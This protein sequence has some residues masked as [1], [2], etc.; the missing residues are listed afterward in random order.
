MEVVKD[1]REKLVARRKA[2]GLTQSDIAIRMGTAQ[3]T[4]SEFE[5]GTKDP[6]FSTFLRYA[7]AVGLDVSIELYFRG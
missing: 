4:V 3:S 5:K 6:R 1:A 2:L 7:D